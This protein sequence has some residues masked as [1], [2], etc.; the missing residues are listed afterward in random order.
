MLLVQALESSKDIAFSNLPERTP[1]FYGREAELLQIR[2]TLDP[3]RP[4]RKS[5]LLIGIGGSGKTQLA[6]QHIE[7]E[8]GR[9]SAIVWI[10]APTADHANRSFIETAAKMSTDWPRDLPLPHHG[11]N[12]DSLLYVASRLRSTRHRNWLLVIDSADD[13]SQDDLARYFPSC[14]YGSVLVTSTKRRVCR[15]FRPASTIS[16]DGLD[17]PNSLAMLRDLSGRQAIDDEGE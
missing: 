6:L 1:T 11:R 17:A 3:S 15:G 12:T 14:D 8:R 10:D 9:Y 4:G 16:V 2:E 5:L 13:I 7:L